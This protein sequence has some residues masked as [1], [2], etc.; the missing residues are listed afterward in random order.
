[1]KMRFLFLLLPL[2]ACAGNGNGGPQASCER[3][4][5]NDPTVRQIVA[6]QAGNG[7]LKN[8]GQAKLADARKRAE[9]KCLRARGL[10]PPGG[11]QPVHPPGSFG[12]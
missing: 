2:A 11:V 1:M 4:A 8:N 7:W 9:V 6:E 3:Q 10:A 12:Y 5:W